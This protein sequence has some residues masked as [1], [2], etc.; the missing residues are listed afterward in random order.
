MQKD[1]PNILFVHGSGQSQLS[2]NYQQVFLSEHNSIF[3]D[4]N[5]QTPVDMIRNDILKLVSEVDGAIVIVAHS[6]GCLIAPLLAEYMD[7][8]SHMV[9][10]SPPW[11]GSNTAKW[12]GRAFRDNSF[13]KN[14]T[15]NSELIQRISKIKI[16]FPLTNIVTSGGANDFA[17]LGSKLNDGM[18]TVESQLS[19]PA[20]FQLVDN[21]EIKTSHSEV[22]LSYDVISIINFIITHEVTNA[23]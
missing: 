12:L 19:I 22:L 2:W 10:L 11:G 5:V 3:A 9:A 6:Y 18:V 17:G 23:H 4:Y 15:P 13:F 7:N 8:I 20:N 21:I 16:D 14:T 1:L